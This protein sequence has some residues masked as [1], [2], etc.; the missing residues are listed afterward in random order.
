MLAKQS[1][2]PAQH[3][4]G[5]EILVQALVRNRV[6]LL[7]G[8]P[9]GA[10]LPVYD[11]FYTESFA[12][13]LTRH[14]QAAVHAAEGYAKTT[15]KT[16]VVCVT[17]GPGASNAMTGI[18]DAMLDSVPLVVL[19]GQV[20]TSVIGTNAFQELDIISMTKAITKANFQPKRVEDLAAIL[21][22][23]FTIA[24]SGR[25]GPVVVD[26][27]K[28][29]MS[30]YMDADQP[31]TPTHF[32]GAIPLKPSQKAMLAEIMQG[33]HQASKPLVLIGAGV[34]A[35]G[36]TEAVRQFL[37]KWQLPVVSTL[38]GLG[39]IPSDDPNFLGMGGMHGTYAANMALDEC[40]FLLNIGARFDDRLVPNPKL[41][42]KDATIAHIDVDPRQ[43]G[44]IVPTQ[45]GVN[46]DAKTALAY[47]LAMPA[48][49]PRPSAWQHLLHLRQTQHPYNY[50]LSH[51]L[52]KP[53]EVIEAVGRVTDGEA[54]VTTDVGQHQMWAAQ[55]YPFKHPKQ[56]VTS[57]GLGTMGFGI[58]AAIG[59]KIANPDKT[60]ILFVGDGGFQMTSEE[61]EVLAT[62]HVNVKM[63]LLNNKTLGMVRQWQDEFYQH[64]RSQT[65]FTHQP[66]FAGLAQAYG[67][68]YAELKKGDDLDQR[69]SKLLASPEPT[70]IQVNIPTN[71]QVYPM[72]APGHANN[73]MMGLDQ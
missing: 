59:A 3:L 36:A 11:S 29:V 45:Y 67:I 44:R 30:A 28:D 42:A 66:N 4:N 65:M 57:G 37:A 51:Q 12:N 63:V 55:Y 40:N 35:A 52:L 8:Y 68:D 17:S 58:P 23:A 32:K 9:G 10:V 26:L 31:A 13:I 64:R 16:G 54:I 27:P 43:I 56:L 15:G 46:A 69:L 18:A 5:S 73:D 62:E 1:P 71:E 53:Q 33:L 22:Q 19:T 38:L 61:L 14:E 41:F 24:Q 7:F 21:D 25:K 20:A 34:S 70:L 50:R 60:V 39:T 49:A 72:I 48:P 2:N 47:L 6:D